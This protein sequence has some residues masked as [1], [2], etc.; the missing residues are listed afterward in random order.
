MSAQNQVREIVPIKG[1]LNTPKSIQIKVTSINPSKGYLN[2][3]L[4]IKNTY[5]ELWDETIFVLNKLRKMGAFTD[6]S[7]PP[8][9]EIITEVS[10]RL[11]DIFGPP[12]DSR[13]EEEY[14]KEPYIISFPLNGWPVPEIKRLIKALKLDIKVKDLVAEQRVQ[15][16]SLS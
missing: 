6:P 1:Y 9:T 16:E 3:T 10:N 12:M 7:F 5:F 13:E 11:G 15:L 2:C 8:Q 14:E 4:S